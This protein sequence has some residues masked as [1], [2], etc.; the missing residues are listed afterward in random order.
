MA[1]KQIQFNKFNDKIRISYDED[2]KLREKRDM[3]LT[4]IREGLRDYALKQGIKI[5]RFDT[6][7]QG[8]Y[9]LRTGIKPLVSEDH[10]ID[11]G[12]VFESKR[13]EL[14]A[15]QIA[16][17]VYNSLLLPNRTVEIK[18][19]CVRVQYH[20]N[21]EKYY[22]VDIAIYCLEKDY[23]N[24]ETYYLSRSDVTGSKENRFWEIAEPKKL[25][26]ILRNKYTKD[27]EFEQF[28]RIIR[29]LK[30]WKDENFSSTGNNRPT[31][32]ALTACAHNWLEPTT[33]YIQDTGKTEYFDLFA[34]Q[35]LVDKIIGDFDRAGKI[36]VNLPVK[37]NNNLFSKM[38]DIQMQ[39]FKSRI[40]VLKENITGACNAKDLEEY[41]KYMRNVFGND[42]PNE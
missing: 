20:R 9:D 15:S 2:S 18:R 21:E 35:K 29:F 8:S 36:N 37:P 11:V 26:D 6:F 17:I 4:N 40:N 33:V 28:R 27:E 38:T 42:F 39:N 5:P 7:N 32:I 22:H 34:L 30:R 41:C 24:N 14:D 25:K 1:S 3:L 19:P 16:K 31:G 10:D 13:T 23:W 12:L